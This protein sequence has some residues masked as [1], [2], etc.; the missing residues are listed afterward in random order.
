[1]SKTVLVTGGTGW[2]GGWCVIELLKRGY[3]VRTTVRSLAKESSVR[4]RVASVIE[5]GDRLYCVAADLTRDDGWEAAATGC[6]YVLHVAS[7]T[8]HDVPKDPNAF[9]AS[10]CDGALRVLRAATRAGVERVVM[11]SSAVAC[12]PPL[13]SADSL[14]DEARWTDPKERNL[15]PYRLSKTLSERAAWNLVA[16]QSGPTTLTTIL[17]SAV[18]GPVLT[19]ENLGTAQIV[20]RML[21]GKM[22]AYPRI[23]FCVA[24]VRDVVD[25]HIRAMI[26]PEAAGERFLAAGDWMWMKD[27]AETLRSSLGSEAA[28][29]PTRPLPDFVMRLVSIFD[30]QTRF[31]I[32][33][34]GRKHANTSAKAQAVL[35]WKPR[36]GDTTIVD[37]AK[38]LIAKRGRPPA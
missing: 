29:V 4:A 10:A 8:V 27:I 36:P 7:P 2:I 33:S 3:T 11:T 19:T 24:D 9:I 38:S 31:F 22:P 14:S 1:M 15:D 21:D 6:T 26:A 37:C 34:L 17:P 13:N 32:P 25:L 35:G 18:L 5:P 12:R 20:Q 28:K 30:R 16:Q 23:G